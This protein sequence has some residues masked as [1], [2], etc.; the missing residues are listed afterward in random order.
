MNKRAFRADTIFALLAF[1]SIF[2]VKLYEL[3]PKNSPKNAFV[4]LPYLYLAFMLYD[5]VV[6]PLFYLS[7][8][9]FLTT[10]ITNLF[11]IH[12]SKTVS[13]ILRSAAGL[14]VLAFWG[15]VAAQTLDGRPPI[16]GFFSG[17]ALYFAA[18][19]LILALGLRKKTAV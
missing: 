4:P 12:L 14:A 10:V 2:Y 8:S 17:Y 6:I 7:V 9:A 18:V 5:F 3:M 11:R 15:F 13:V 16:Y 19:G 1:L